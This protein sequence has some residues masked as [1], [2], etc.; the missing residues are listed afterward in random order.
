[1]KTE[2][3]TL[4]DPSRRVIDYLRISITDRCNE[5]CLYCMPEI[6]KDWKPRTDILSFEEILKI[7]RVATR[8]GF[9]KFRITGGEPLIRLD[10]V[11]FIEALSRIPGVESIGLSTNGTRLESLATGL[12]RAGVHNLNI[13]L[14]ALDPEIYRRITAGNVEPVLKGIQKAVRLGFEKI[15][16]NMVLIRGMNESQIWPLINFA[17]EH[18]LPLRFIEL[19]PVSTSEVLSEKN[20]FPISELMRVLSERDTLIPQQEIKMGHGPAKYYRMKKTGA[21]IGFIGAITT[22]HFCEGCNKIRLTADGKLRPCLGNHGEL[23]I[24]TALR[25]EKTDAAI[26]SVLRKSIIEKPLEHIFRNNYVPS[27]IMTAIGG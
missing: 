15:K 3:S 10:V 8:L 4:I 12:K 14:D 19:M 26:E 6:F 24:K 22:E 21:L 1:M 27:R 11:E 7:V 17:S 20:F 18:H 16:L 13:S 23:D 5:R 25:E 2:G 9:K